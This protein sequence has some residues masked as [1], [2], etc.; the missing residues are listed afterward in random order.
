MKEVGTHL[1]KAMLF[2]AAPVSVSR[3]E[4]T[5]AINHVVAAEPMELLTIALAGQI[6]RSFPFALRH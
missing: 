4:A 2:T 6:A 3:L 1:L 5:G